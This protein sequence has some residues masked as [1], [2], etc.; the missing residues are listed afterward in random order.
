MTKTIELYLDQ[1]KNKVKG[2][3][4]SPII[5]KWLNSQCMKKPLAIINEQVEYLMKNGGKKKIDQWFL[6]NDRNFNSITAERYII[7][8]LRKQN[9][10]II[11]NLRTDGIDAYLNDEKSPVGIE[12]TTLNGFVASWIFVERLTELLD[13]SGFLCDKGLELICSHRRIW[14]ASR[15]GS[16]NKFVKLAN[17]AIESNNIENLSSLNLSVEFQHVFPGSISFS[18]KNSDDFPWFQYITDD[19]S[20]KLQKKSKANQLKNYSRNIVFVGVNHLSPGNWAFPGIF[21]D[22]GSD[23]KRFKSEI[24]ELRDYWLTNMASLTNV[25]GICYFFYS[26]DNE[27]PFYPL[28]IFWRSEEDKIDITL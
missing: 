11:D 7:S 17:A 13:S 1:R 4:P 26:L 3:E 20:Q 23:E 10:N 18:F 24:Q 28:K 14:D 8:Y 19:L 22:L 12:I 27:A 21:R 2:I 15:D 25:I 6:T 9:R 16:I 5:L